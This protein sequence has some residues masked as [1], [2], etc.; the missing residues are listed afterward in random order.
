MAKGVFHHVG[1]RQSPIV[2]YSRT[3]TYYHVLAYEAPQT[4][5]QIDTKILKKSNDIKTYVTGF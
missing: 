3:T 5:S 1:W 2:I 4:T